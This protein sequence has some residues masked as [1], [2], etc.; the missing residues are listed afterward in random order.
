MGDGGWRIRFADQAEPGV[1]RFL[2]RAASFLTLAGLTALLVG[3]IGVATGVRAWLEGRGRTIATLRC[4]GAPS[5]TILATYLIQVLVLSMVGIAIG[6]VAGFGLTWL[7]AQ[8]L[9]GALPVPPRFG[10]YPGA[11]AIAAL[12]G[13]LTALAFALWPLGRA[14]RVP[15][16]A[17]FRDTITATPGWPS[18]GIIAANLLAA[19][20][21]VVLVVGTAEQPLFALGFCGGAAATLLLF[22]LGATVLMALA[23]SLKHLRRPALRLGLA[24]LYRPGAPTPIMLIALGIGLTTLATI[25]TIEGNLR[26]QIADQLPQ[27][28]PSFFFIDI[29]NDQAEDFDRLARG[30]PGV[31][32]V[33]RVPSL[34]ARIVA[35][36]GTPAEQVNATEETR[37]AL[38]GDRGLT[39]AA[40]PPDGTRLV[41][42]EWWAA[43][44]QGPTLV[45]FDANLAKGWGVGIGSVL[46]VNVLG[47]DLDLKIASLRDIQWRGLGINYTLVAS[48]GLLASAPH[49]HIATVRAAAS[50]EVGVLRAITDAFPNVSGIRVRDALEAVA[51]LLGRIGVALQ[52]TSSV[53]LLAGMLVL[54]GAVAAGQ[55]A[56]VR[57]A[58]ILKTIGATRGQIRNAWLVEF[59]LL[60][61]VAGLLAAAAGSA[62]SWAVVRFVMRGEWVFL[63]GTLALTVLG[64]IMLTLGFGYVGTALALRVRPAALLRNE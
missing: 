57:D 17:L 37:W 27:A 34:R 3:G 39:Y 51:N 59:G 60:G 23:R 50:S 5:G 18:R 55:A 10:F 28:A 64:C 44:Y 4:L 54:A 56:R 35:V 2:D 48:P 26:R 49:T 30:L 42:G 61:L 22:R 29:Q 19:L 62:A 8:A 32:E 40:T 58:V 24:N 21:L 46:T 25:A 53:T 31:A 9:A 36:N 12:Y 41:A 63:P 15:G 14:Q 52:A 33:R 45:S 1:N 11:L 20:A 16:A 47:R 43:D 38:R 7:A 13:L 6:L